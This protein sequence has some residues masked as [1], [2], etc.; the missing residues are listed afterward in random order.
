MGVGLA[1]LH[2][3]PIENEAHLPLPLFGVEVSALPQTRGPLFL[4]PPS[5]PGPLIGLLLMHPA[6]SAGLAWFLDSFLLRKWRQNSCTSQKTLSVSLAP[7][8]GRFRFVRPNAVLRN[9]LFL[10]APAAYGN[11]QARD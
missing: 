6:R 8:R 9:L 2:I 10:S 7:F 11:S 1:W 3:P 5:L 4:R